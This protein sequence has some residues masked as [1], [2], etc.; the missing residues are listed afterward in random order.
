MTKSTQEDWEKLER[1]SMYLNM[2]A[3]LGIED[4]GTHRC[5]LC[6]S[7]G[8]EGTEWSHDHCWYCPVS[9]SSKKQGLVTKSST[10]AELVAISDMLS[11]VIWTREFLQDQ[12][13][14]MAPGIIYQDNKSTI[15][16]VNRGI[17]NSPRTR[18]VAIRYFLQSGEVVIEHMGTEHMLADGMSK[19]LQ[20][21]LFRVMRRRSMGMWWSDWRQCRGAL[22]I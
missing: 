8:Y 19:P 20:G 4:K 9:V 6:S 17:S 22:K 12:G 14:T 10:E 18:H 16:M 1:V 13:Y 3:D 5:E 2:T 21:D 15:A 7:C 11:M